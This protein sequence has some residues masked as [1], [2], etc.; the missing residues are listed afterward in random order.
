MKASSRVNGLFSKTVG[1]FAVQLIRRISRQARLTSSSSPKGILLLLFSFS[2]F[3][4]G[5]YSK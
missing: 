3:A 4:R 5:L 1:L 2:G